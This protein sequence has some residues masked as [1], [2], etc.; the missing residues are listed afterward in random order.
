MPLQRGT[1]GAGNDALHRLDGRMAG[2]HSA[3]AFAGADT[4]VMHALAGLVGDDALRG[5]RHCIR[6]KTL[7]L[8]E[9]VERTADA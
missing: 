6:E 9:L 1:I 8:Q 4:A 3:R 2:A 5:Q 7:L